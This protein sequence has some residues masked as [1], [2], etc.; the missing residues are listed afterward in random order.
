MPAPTSPAVAATVLYE[1]LKFIH[2]IGATVVGGGGVLITAL[3]ASAVI[4]R[5]GERI[6]AV[7]SI[8]AWVGPRVFAPA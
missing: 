3:L 6:Q 7:S 8:G 5:N 1:T 4:G 2:I